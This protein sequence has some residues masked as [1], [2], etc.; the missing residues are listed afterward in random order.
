M[1][2]KQKEKLE[3]I[4]H[5]KQFIKKGDTIFTKIEKVSTSGM[6]RHIKVISIKKNNPNYWSYYV[7]KIL[8]WSYKDKT[9]AVGVGGCGMDMGFHLVYTLSRILF[10]DGYALKQRWI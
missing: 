1:T 7:A 5:L 9:N 3:A 6:Y 8:E 2:K 4:K 10:K